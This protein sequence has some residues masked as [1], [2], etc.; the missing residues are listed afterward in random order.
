VIHVPGD[1]LHGCERAQ[2]S[3]HAFRDE[4]ACVQDEVRL[5]QEPNAL[6]GE[7]AD[8]TRKVRIRDDCDERQR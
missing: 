6:L 1:C 3:E 4:I 2:L 5:R 8:A 7:P